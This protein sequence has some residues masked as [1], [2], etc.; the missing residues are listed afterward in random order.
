MV[1]KLNLDFRKSRR[2]FSRKKIGDCETLI[3]P[4]YDD[5]FCET[6]VK[7]RKYKLHD[8]KKWAKRHWTVLL[9]VLPL[10]GESRL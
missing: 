2:R 7:R 9:S 4:D 6:K 3:M 5:S 8:R 10:E 1:C